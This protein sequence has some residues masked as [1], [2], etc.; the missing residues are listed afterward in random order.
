MTE[1]SV[2]LLHEIFNYRDG[3]LYWKVRRSHNAAVGSRAGVQHSSGYRII[4]INGKP[5][6]EHRLIF[7]MYYG[8]L[9]KEVDHIDGNKLNNRIENLRSATTSQNQHNRTKYKNNTSGYKGVSFYGKNKYKCWGANIQVNGKQKHLGYFL[10]PE[11]AF[12]AYCK[13]ALELH[14]EF[15]NTGDTV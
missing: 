10:T 3:E 9:P 12:A 5:H 11:E 13:A 14:G 7:L 1:L 8:Y 2:D 15:A 6:K 4:K